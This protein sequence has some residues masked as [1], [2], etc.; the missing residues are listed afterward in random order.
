MFDRWKLRAEGS[1]GLDPGEVGGY[2]GG[3]ELRAWGAERLGPAGK[4]EVG[5][6]G[7]RSLEPEGLRGWAPGVG[8]VG[9]CMQPVGLRG[10]APGGMEGG[11][12]GGRGGRGGRGRERQR[13]RSEE[14]ETGVFLHICLDQR[15]LDSQGS[16]RQMNTKHPS[17]PSGEQKPMVQGIKTQDMGVAPYTHYT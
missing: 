13:G 2:P 5:R 1:V 11:T 3:W 16:R 15:F 6:V 9:A 14:A 8:R 4:W 10:W 12:T 7:R 17:A